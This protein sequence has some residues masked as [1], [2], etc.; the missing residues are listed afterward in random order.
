[1]VASTVPDLKVELAALGFIGSMFKRIF[2][3][4]QKIVLII[5]N[6]IIPLFK[7]DE[8]VILFYP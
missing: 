8:I 7:F 4:P 2:I 6:C 5:F 1:M 3:L